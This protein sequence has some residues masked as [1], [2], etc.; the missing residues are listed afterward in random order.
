MMKAIA[1]PWLCWHGLVLLSGAYGLAQSFV[2]L[3]VF[4]NVDD[5]VELCMLRPART[6]GAWAMGG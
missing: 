3:L 6:D 4:V 1:L 2:W 5:G